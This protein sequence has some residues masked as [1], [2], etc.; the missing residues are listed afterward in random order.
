MSRFSVRCGDH[1][2][3]GDPEEEWEV[4]GFASAEVAREYA[5]RFIRAQIEDLR[6]DA[7]SEE[8][9]RTMYFNW[10]EYAIAEGLDTVAWVEFCLANPASRKSETDYQ[11]LEPRG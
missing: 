6:Q 3:A 2:D 8:I 5:R 9:L 7:A 10:G 1:A 4:T 11:A